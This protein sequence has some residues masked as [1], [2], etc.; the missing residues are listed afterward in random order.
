MSFR[1]FKIY[2]W[3]YYYFLEALVSITSFQLFFLLFTEVSSLGVC[4]ETWQIII[5]TY[6][7]RLRSCMWELDTE[8]YEDHVYVEERVSNSPFF[9]EEANIPERSN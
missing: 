7:R 2:G 6:A 1:F 5:T 9:L 3:K 8:G 4:H